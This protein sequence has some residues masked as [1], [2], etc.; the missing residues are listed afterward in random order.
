MDRFVGMY[1]NDL[2][3]DYREDGRRAVQRLLDVAYEKG[4]VPE[5]VVA[6]FLDTGAPATHRG[7]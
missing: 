3:V 2:T 7:N 5:R 4:I 6:E 1:V